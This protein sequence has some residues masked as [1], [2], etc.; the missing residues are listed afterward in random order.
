M[1][2]VRTALA[3]VSLLC[4]TVSPACD[5]VDEALDCASICDKYNDCVSSDI[6]QDE[7]RDSCEEWADENQENADRL[8][9]CQ[10]CVDDRSCVESGF[11]CIAQCAFIPTG[12]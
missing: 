10:S 5:E 7:C 4:L 6:D 11:Q 3:L 2:A 1:N 12:N 9:D 8:D